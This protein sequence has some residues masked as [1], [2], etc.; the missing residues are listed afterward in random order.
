MH[1]KLIA[2]D[3]DGTLADS[4]ACFR[5]SLNV[6]AA[7]H[8]FR[9]LDDTL[10]DQAR[11]LSARGVLQLLGVPLWKTPRITVEMRRQMS[12]SAAQIRLFPGI[13]DTLRQLAARGVRIAV[14]TSNAESLVRATLGPA[15]EVVTDFSCGLSVFGKKR[16]LEA[17]IA[18]A[19]LRPEQTLYVG[20][21][22]RDAQAAQGAGIP[23]RG[24]SW[25]YTAP[26][27]LQQHCGA[28]L[29]ERPEDLLAL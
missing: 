25:G 24:V 7:R 21:E 27:A 14:A 1:Y 4:F 17:L 26:A 19:G 12:E 23:F 20:D 3:F 9:A 5:A 28:P 11:G 15:C 6:S 13:D 22:I 16:K 10:L 8:G 29:L 18:A 2:F